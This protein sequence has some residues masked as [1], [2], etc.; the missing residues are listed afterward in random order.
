MNRLHCFL[1]IRV[2]RKNVV[3]LKEHKFV[4]HLEKTIK[5]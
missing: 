3:S 2:E 5:L 1:R 4:K